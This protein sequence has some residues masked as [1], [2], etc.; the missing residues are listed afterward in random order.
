L[1]CEGN[2]VEEIGKSL[3]AVF[4]RHVRGTNPQLVEILAPLWSRVAGRGIAEHSRPVAYWSGTLT[5]ATS[6]ATWAAQLRQLEPE[7]LEAVNT[8]LGGEIV[9]KLQVRFVPD[10]APLEKEN[11]KP[12]AEFFKSD[13]FLAGSVDLPGSL[14]P[15]TAGVLERSYGKYFARGAKR[16]S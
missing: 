3:P 6:C 10:R 12:G 5:L 2:V 9:K 13:P 4:K 16:L 14:D 7:V 15:E 11:G 8:F 1:N